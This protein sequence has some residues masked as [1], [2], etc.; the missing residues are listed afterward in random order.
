MDYKLTATP[1]DARGKKLR[2]LRAEGR[3][4]AIVYGHRQPAE[5][6]LLDG[7]EFR[8]VF[9]RAGR[10]HLLDLAI[11]GGRAEKVIIKEVQTHPR[12][13]G[14]VHVDFYRIDLK[15]KLQVEVPI[16]FTGEAPAVKNGDGDLLTS[17]HHL[18][19]ECLPGDIPDSIPVDLSG[20]D[21]IDAGVRVGD[22]VV[23]EGV[24]VLHDPEDLIV[25][26]HA[27]RVVVE[28]EAAPEEGA[29]AVAEGEEPAAEGEE[30]Q[31]EGESE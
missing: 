24:T 7:H 18:R 14:A 13:Q 31:A 30:G 25:K 21:E 8:K 5:P 9:A 20:L 6:L 11:D 12:R 17:L 3:L 2:R 10:S 26:V 22:V 27:H 29:E 15:E 1:R 28:E 16:D 23:P 19:V 4:P